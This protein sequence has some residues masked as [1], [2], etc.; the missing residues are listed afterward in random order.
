MHSAL[1]VYP[2]ARSHEKM[3][4]ILEVEKGI[5]HGGAG[6][7]DHDSPGTSILYFAGERKTHL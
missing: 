5:S 7:L 2:D 4:A 1:T 3:P 6:I